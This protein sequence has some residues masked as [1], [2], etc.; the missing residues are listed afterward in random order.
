MLPIT[1]INSELDE[2]LENL[3]SHRNTVYSEF[4]GYVCPMRYVQ[5]N[6]RKHNEQWTQPGCGWVKY[7]NS[8]FICH[9]LSTGCGYHLF[10][11]KDQ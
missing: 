6:R 1:N 7:R 8:L 4:G 2:E 9:A 3:Y 10:M 5:G 11:D